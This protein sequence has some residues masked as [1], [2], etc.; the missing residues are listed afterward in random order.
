VKDHRGRYQISFTVPGKP[1]GKGRPR[2]ARVGDYVKTYTPA[3]TRA[4][5]QV[6]R[7]AFIDKAEELGIIYPRADYGSIQIWIRCFFPVPQAWPKWK[8]EYAAGETMPHTTKGADWDNLGKIICDALNT[9][10]WQDDAHISD[11]WVIRRYSTNPRTEVQI[12]F[13]PPITRA[14]VQQMEAP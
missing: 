12:I 14:T 6:I 3:E 4:W 11:G 5:E 9:V 1:K 10:A 13:Y 2:F 8:K 7:D